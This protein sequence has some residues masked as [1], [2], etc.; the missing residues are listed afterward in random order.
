MNKLEGLVKKVA[1]DKEF[2]AAMDNIG[3]EPEFLSAKDFAESLAKDRIWIAET[4]K[5]LYKSDN[6]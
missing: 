5:R 4:V 1:E 2:I 3:E 6:P